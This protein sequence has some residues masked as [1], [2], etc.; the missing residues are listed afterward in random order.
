[1]VILRLILSF[2]VSLFPSRFFFFFFSYHILLLFRKRW[3]MIWLLG[4]QKSSVAI[5]W[6]RHTWKSWVN[7]NETFQSKSETWENAEVILFCAELHWSLTCLLPMELL[8][9]A[10]WVDV[11]LEFFVIFLFGVEWKNFFLFFPVK[12]VTVNLRFHV[13]SHQMKMANDF[14]LFDD[15][16]AW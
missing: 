14:E 3:H 5:P 8:V 11:W 7:K 15:F 10:W 12:N 6:L 16:L 9:H 1:M 4:Q 13:F 2:F